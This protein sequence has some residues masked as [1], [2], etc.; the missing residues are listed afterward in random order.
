MTIERLADT[1]H[2]KLVRLDTLPQATFLTDK[3][4]RRRTVSK[5]FIA[6][7]TK[8]R[9]RNVLCSLRLCQN[10]YQPI[11]KFSIGWC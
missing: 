3:D 11:V 7:N 10:D 6:Y 1:E 2:R 8:N 9:A 5:V 4:H